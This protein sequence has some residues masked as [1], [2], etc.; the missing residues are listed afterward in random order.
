M[1]RNNR[2]IE[3]GKVSI[4]ISLMYLLVVNVEGVLSI[5]IQ[6]Y[7][8]IPKSGRPCSFERRIFTELH[9]FYNSPL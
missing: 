9:I 8:N 7:G 6:S 1:G 4:S 5:I 3:I 2:I